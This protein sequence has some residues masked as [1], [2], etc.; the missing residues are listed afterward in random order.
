MKL[1]RYVDH[2]RLHIVTKDVISLSISV[3]L[4]FRHYISH[5]ISF[6]APSSG[7]VLCSACGA[8]IEVGIPN[9]VW[10]CILGRRSVTYH[11][12]VTVTLTFDL[13]LR[14]L[15]WRTSLTF[16]KV[17]I[18]NL[19]CKCTLDGNLVCES[20]LKWRIVTFYFSVTVTLT[21]D[22]VSRIGI[23]SDAKLLYFLR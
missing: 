4:L 16:F 2:Q 15:V 12:R 8:F 7:G 19:L 17:G 5:K 21:F 20:I 23:K 3:L 11:I 13:V 1:H 9:L 6:G 18:P 10:K 14:I 22:L